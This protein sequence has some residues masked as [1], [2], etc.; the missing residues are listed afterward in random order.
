M[1]RSWWRRRLLLIMIIMI[2]SIMM[3]ISDLHGP[4]MNGL[5]TASLDVDF[6]VSSDRL[7]FSFFFLLPTRLW[8]AGIGFQWPFFF[9]SSTPKIKALMIFFFKSKNVF[10]HFSIE[11][12]LDW[13]FRKK[14]PFFLLSWL[15]NRFIELIVRVC[16]WIFSVDKKENHVP[17]FFPFFSR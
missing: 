13:V 14:G 10:S 5:I 4:Q 16:D 12:L 17:Y 15:S 6:P 8:V 9:Y 3:M 1:R 7:L 2:I 11:H